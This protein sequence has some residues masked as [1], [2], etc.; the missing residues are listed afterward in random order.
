MNEPSRLTVEQF[1]ARA[2]EQRKRKGLGHESTIDHK[3]GV[4]GHTHI[5]LHTLEARSGAVFPPCDYQLAHLVL[6]LCNKAA[7]IECSCSICATAT[8][9]IHVRL[10]GGKTTNPLSSRSSNNNNNKCE[11]SVCLSNNDYSKSFRKRLIDVLGQ[12]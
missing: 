7:Q 3:T 2:I 4:G 1:V 6:N 8:S 12:R 9:N 10:S 11:V 5:H